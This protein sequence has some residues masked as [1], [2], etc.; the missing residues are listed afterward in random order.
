MNNNILVESQ[1][2]RIDQKAAFIDNKLYTYFPIIFV[3]LDLLYCV[4]VHTCT[5]GPST[6]ACRPYPPQTC[7]KYNTP[8]ISDNAITSD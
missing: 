3:T 1:P 5:N 2:F 4:A 6:F 7:T 8:L